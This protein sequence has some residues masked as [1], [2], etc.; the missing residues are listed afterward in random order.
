MVCPT[1]DISEVPHPFYPDHVL[2]LSLKNSVIFLAAPRE[3]SGTLMNFRLLIVYKGLLKDG[4][5]G[6]V[7]GVALLL[8]RGELK[9]CRWLRG[10]KGKLLLQLLHI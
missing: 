1:C 10:T 6:Q 3:K 7:L 5:L 9:D 4:R 2:A 8:S